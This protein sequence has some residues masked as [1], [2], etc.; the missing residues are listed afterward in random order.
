MARI[1]GEI[2]QI[3]WAKAYFFIRNKKGLDV[4]LNLF[5]YLQFIDKTTVNIFELISF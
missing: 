1:F 5:L 2:K 3:A 4:N